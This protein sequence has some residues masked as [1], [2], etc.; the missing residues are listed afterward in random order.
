MIYVPTNDKTEGKHGDN[1]EGGTKN[2]TLEDFACDRAVVRSSIPQGQ[3]LLPVRYHSNQ[4][5]AV[6]VMPTSQATKE[7][8]V[9]NS[10]QCNRDVN[11]EE[12]RGRLSGFSRF[13]T[14]SKH[15][16]YVGLIVS[17]GCRSM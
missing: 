2:T 14:L 8:V 15:C 5:R 4:R 9:L 10:D 12:G 13:L 6:S 11:E 3:K 1:E 17:V 7:E 16:P